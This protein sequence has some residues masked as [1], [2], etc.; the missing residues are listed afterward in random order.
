[1]NNLTLYEFQ[2][3]A[4][5]SVRE[6]WGHG[7]RVCLV[8]P[9]GSGKTVMGQA[10]TN[11]ERVLWVVHNKELLQ[12]TAGR[13][14][15]VGVI[16]SGHYPRNTPT[17]VAMIQTL[18]RRGMR[19]DANVIVLDEAHHYRA[20]T[21]QEVAEAYPGARVVGLTATPERSDGRA[22][23][24]VFD[25]LVVAA[26]YPELIA[27][28]RL[29]DA[30]TIRPSKYLGSDMAQ[31]PVEAWSQYAPGSQ[32]FVFCA[33]KS[34]AEMYEARYR[35]IGVACATIHD[36]TAR[37]DRE[38]HMRDFRAGK[39]MVLLNVKVLSEGVDVPEAAC[40]I[41][42]RAFQT[43]GPYLQ[44]IGRV[45]RPAPGKQR[46]IVIDLPGASHRHGLPGDFRDFSLSGKP[47][48]VGEGHEPPEN[49]AA[50][51]QRVIGA[52]LETV[53]PAGVEY[54]LPEPFHPC[55]PQHA[56]LRVACEDCGKELRRI[57]KRAGRCIDCLYR[58]AN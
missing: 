51:E 16:A 53:I 58:R 8:S 4:V 26:N 20:D 23:G 43:P 15:N 27:G 3:R 50:F 7:K 29:V 42:A 5:N 45:L 38:S 39:T 40:C 49:V 28:G 12:Q 18:C 22:L 6:A 25:H 19:P 57:E 1:M 24:D 47:I 33:R 36:G 35:N 17:R 30:V 11:G 21:W 34:L 31:D 9:T 55:A 54:E 13:L 14:G 56:E 48:S 52:P 46:A 32:T 10:L 2:E 37:S 44:A 41:L